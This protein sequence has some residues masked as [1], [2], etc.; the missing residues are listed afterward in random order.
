MTLDAMF[1]TKSS[2]LICATP[3]IELTNARSV[4]FTPYLLNH[5]GGHSMDQNTSYTRMIAHMKPQCSTRMIITR[6]KL[7]LMVEEPRYLLIN[8]VVKLEID[9]QVQI[10]YIVF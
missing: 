6:L 5:A 9:L 4:D 3:R 1:S 8:E 2:Q 7:I 10:S